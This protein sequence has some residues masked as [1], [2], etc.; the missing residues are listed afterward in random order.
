[1][2]IGDSVSVLD[3]QIKGKITAIKGDKISIEDQHGFIYDYNKN[4]VV[5][6]ESR[7]YEDIEIVKKPEFSKAISKKH[8]KNPFILDLHFEK[9]SK[10]RGKID[11][12]ERLFL[13]KEK[14][15]AT[16]E[17]CRKNH[18]KKLEIIHGIGDGILQQMV[19][20]VLESQTNIE[21]HNKEIL[22]HQSATVLVY[23]R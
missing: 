6:N 21:F 13:Q 2:K 23:L 4:E 15:L 10:S 16:L 12:F 8:D 18:L 5:S 9:L 19:Y 1:M 7:I 3:D 22:H 11:S 14:L 17:Y 20:D